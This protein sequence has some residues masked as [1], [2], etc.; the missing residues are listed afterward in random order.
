MTASAIVFL[1]FLALPG[2]AATAA[3]QEPSA[4]KLEFDTASVHRDKSGHEPT[5]NVPLGPGDV[6]PPT[7]G[8]L[9]ARNFSLMDYIEFAYKLKDY[10]E[11]SVRAKLPDWAQQERFTIQAR[12][13]K[14]NVT[15]DELRLMMR[16]LLAERFKLELRYESRSVPVLALVLIKPG[17]L[18]PDLQAHPSGRPCPKYSPHATD[19]NGSPLPAVPKTVA[20]GFPTFCGGILGIPA[21]AEDRYKFG[22]RDVAMSVVASSLDSW[23]HLDRPVVDE[24]GLSGTY[25]FALEFTP[26]PRPSYATVDSGGLTFVEALR[27]QLGL[28]LERKTGTLQFAV[29]DHVEEPTEN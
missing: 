22:A 23:G 29:V 14:E 1:C 4:Q 6:Y 5:S 11:E 28:K 17:T 15:K 12:T 16:S 20:K 10:Q 9:Y 13:D 21:S 25:D 24:T 18:G 27:Q 26:E 7:G 2:F 19:E 3:G 8:L